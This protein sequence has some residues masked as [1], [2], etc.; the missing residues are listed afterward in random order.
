MPA[1]RPLPPHLSRS[2][3][4]TDEWDFHE[5]SASRLRSS[6][7]D[8]PFHGVRSVG[9]DAGDILDLA[10]M[11]APRLRDGQLFSHITA[12]RL[13]GIPLPQ[14]LR[15]STMVHVA[16]VRGTRV[17]AKGV[18]GHLMPDAVA[19]FVEELR[20]VS[21]A[22]TWCQLAVH[23]S[24]E[25][26]VAGGDYLLTGLR[27]PGGYRAAPLCTRAELEGAAE[28]HGSKRGAVALAWAGPL[29]RAGVDSPRESMLRLAIIAHGLP[30]PVVG[31]PVP[32]AEGLTLHPDLSY[33]E[34][35]IAIEYEGDE[36]RVDR[37]RWRRDLRRISLLE[38][39]GW[40]VIRVTN[41]DI[42][43]STAL[44]RILRAALR[45]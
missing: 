41:D 6:L 36:H 3:F 40:R 7:V 15:T 8:A 26:L 31:H 2:A 45:A 20:V 37:T 21:P 10:R 13:H 4:R 34:H 14:R 32:V 35:R 22:Q 23:V 18:V 29:L 33:P 42:A 25:Y 9:L 44:V 43:D 24:R 1:P 27:L 39:A 11:Y 28:R 5:L 16:S 19:S 12:A 17:R 30:E 38:E